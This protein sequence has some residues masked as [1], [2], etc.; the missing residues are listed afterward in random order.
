MERALRDWMELAGHFRQ[1]AD[2]QSAGQK[3]SPA[4]EGGRGGAV[5]QWLLGLTPALC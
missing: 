2:N 1:Q 4:V 5:L 3:N